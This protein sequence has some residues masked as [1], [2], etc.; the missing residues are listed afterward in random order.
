MLDRENVRIDL[1]KVRHKIY[2]SYPPYSEERKRFVREAKISALEELAYSSQMTSKEAMLAMID[3]SKKLMVK[4][5]LKVSGF[6][7]LLIG[8]FYLYPYLHTTLESILIAI[9]QVVLSIGVFVYLKCIRNTLKSLKSLDQYYTQVHEK[10]SKMSED[11]RK[12]GG[13]GEF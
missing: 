1:L 8:A 3:S 11:I 2:T 4:E 13:P 7:I 5:V 9:I 10:M 12:L 6:I